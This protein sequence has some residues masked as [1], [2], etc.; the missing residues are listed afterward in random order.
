MQRAVFYKLDS[1]GKT[2]GS[3][4]SVMF[5]PESYSV[6]SK[7]VYSPATSPQLRRET[8]Q[9]SNVK[10]RTLSLTL[11]FD[12][13]N[14]PSKPMEQLSMSASLKDVFRGGTKDVRSD[15]NELRSMIE[16]TDS[17]KGPPPI[18]IFQWGG[19]SF[20]GVVDSFKEDYTIFHSDGRPIRAN[21]SVTMT[22][23]LGS[24][25]EMGAVSSALEK[26]ADNMIDSSKGESFEKAAETALK[27]VI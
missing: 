13:M 18:V 4:I 16:L 12:A 10:A 19:F 23:Y 17:D 9:F 7:A 1:K 5:N 3:G 27:S 8:L 15:I 21:V 22:E 26:A 11:L 6:S 24:S 14:P 25:M 2:Q 20:R